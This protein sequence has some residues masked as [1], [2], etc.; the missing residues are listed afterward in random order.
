MREVDGERKYLIGDVA[1]MVGLSRDALR[2]YEKKGVISSEK[3]ENGYRCYSDS[4]IYKLVHILYYRKMNISLGDLEAL[5]SGKEE[6]LV[7]T[8]EHLARRIEEEEAELRRRMRALD[9]LRMTQRDIGRIEKCTDRCS[10]Q[11]FPAAY[12][13]GHCSNFREGIHKWFELSSRAE[14]LDMTYFYNRLC[15]SENGLKEDGTDLLFYCRLEQGM[16]KDVSFEDCP[17]TEERDC[18]YQVIQSEITMPERDEVER[19]IQWGKKQGLNTEP[20]VYSNVMTCFFEGD[21]PRYCQELYLP[22]TKI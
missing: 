2:F 13:L 1:Q 3:M 19:M 22:I 16:E 4:D 10:V 12:V 21:K 17:R 7:S 9:R 14:G 6:P 5:M 11:K 20:L 15:I 18:I 8:Q